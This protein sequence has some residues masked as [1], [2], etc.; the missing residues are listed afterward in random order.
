MSED[1]NDKTTDEARTGPEAD[2]NREELKKQAERGIR[3]A[4]DHPPKESL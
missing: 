4:K 2:K 1:K 3:A